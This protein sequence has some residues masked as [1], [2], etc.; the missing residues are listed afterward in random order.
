MNRHSP[1][2]AMAALAA[3]SLMTLGA[4]AQSYPVK[5]VK[6]IVPHPSGG[7]PVDLPARG[8]AEAWTKALGQPFVVENR[9]GAD[10]LIGAEALAKS[11]P[12]GYTLGVTSASV[13]TMNELTRS[14][15]PYNSARD[16]APVAYIGAIESL[17]LVNTSVP[18]KTLKDLFELAKAKPGTITWGTLGTM[19]NGPL[20]IGLFRQNL[21]LQFYM[22]P[23]KSNIQ[24]VQGAVAGDVNAV[25]YAAGG[26][27]PFI[28]AGKLR[29]LAYTG[30]TRYSELPDVPT[31][32][33]LGVKLAFKT[34]I[35]T[36]APA[37]TPTDIVRRVNAEAV[38]A[39]TDT[40]FVKKFLESQGVDAG[41]IARSSP[42]EFARFI[43]D[44]R[45]AYEEAVKAAGIERK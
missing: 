42:E 35:G 20:L 23:Y 27:M 21:G 10:G 9:D 16:F 43:R 17:M 6:I 5:P 25:A 31:F 38:K 11:S 44:D 14:S 34:W 29:P 24:A 45:S 28:K 32:T 22:I 40:A 7:G 18:A 41:P 4:H 30:A 15:L 36:F 12:D 19:S 26:A 8:L 13:I 33:E 2:F 1:M 37:K 39:L 3:S